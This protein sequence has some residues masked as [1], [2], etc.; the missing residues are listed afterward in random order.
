MST[1]PLPLQ[2]IR[3]LDLGRIYQGPWC[4]LLLALAGA[5]VIKV[6]EPKGEPARGGQTGSTVP[7][8]LLNSNKQAITLDLKESRGRELFLQ[9]A[10]AA[11]VVIE[12][13]GPGTM[14]RLGVGPDVL[15]E[16]NPRLVYGAATGYGIDG[17]DRDLL[18]MDITIQ[19]HGGI[20]SVTGFPENPPVKAGAAFVD[21]H[22]GTTL[23]AGVMTALFERERTGL[24]RVVDVAMIDTIYPTLTSNLTG[25]FRTG[26]AP[27]A[28]NGHGGAP[29][30]PYNVYPCAGG[31]YVAIIGVTQAHWRNLCVAM[32]RP[33]LADDERFVTNAARFRNLEALDEAI[34]DWT[35]AL[36]R[37][38]VVA[39]LRT[40][41][42]PAAAVRDVKEMVEDAHLH[43]RGAIQRIDHP[44]AG[45][46]V[47]P[48]SPLRFRGTPLAPLT[49]SPD[50]GANNQAVFG[51][52][53]GLGEAE[54]ADLA[55]D[56][57]I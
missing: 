8:A 17:P 40:A 51:E 19:A 14:D 36:E 13:F 16:A 5:E 30:L 26:K 35:R 46:L 55:K 41:R 56:G 37:D 31:G 27:R 50:L 12:N 23:Y 48:H 28:G 7:I 18:A 20:M 47:V 45:D 25:Y 44:S 57:V 29:L 42:V 9:L 24:G 4:G 15:L 21:F 53:L 49:P 43:Q 34:G 3:V 39:R 10:R 52:W 2:G 32:E 22:G 6:E 54:V 38:D 11:D 33:E 1:R